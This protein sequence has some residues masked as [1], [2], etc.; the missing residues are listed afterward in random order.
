MRLRLAGTWLADWFDRLTASGLIPG[1]LLLAF[2]L[3]PSLVPRTP[4]FQGLVS[5]LSLTLG[6]L[7]GGA[8]RRVWSY[9]ELPAP[10][11]R[12][13]RR[14]LQVAAAICIGTAAVFL[15]RAS[16]WQN[17]VRDIMGMEPVETVRPYTV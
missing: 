9:L 13:H 11:A 1:T 12:M 17:S 5:G 4:L 2:S 16:E 3:S 8:V 10:G 15:W 6:D 14:V 7:L